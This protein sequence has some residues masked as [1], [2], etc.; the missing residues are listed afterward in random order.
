MLVCVLSIDFSLVNRNVWTWSPSYGVRKI[1]LDIAIVL[2]IAICQAGWDRKSA[3]SFVTL[4][5]RS[6]VLT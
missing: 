2:K 3:I 4:Q 1:V 6:G 5:I